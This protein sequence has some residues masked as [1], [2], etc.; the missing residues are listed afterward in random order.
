MGYSFDK[1][2][3]KN[4]LSISQVESLVSEL[5]GEP[6]EIEG[7]F[8]SKTICHCGEQHKLF[9]YD[10]TKLFRCYTEC[11]ETFDIISLVQ[12]VKSREIEN[13]SFANALKYVAAFFGIA[14]AINDDEDNFSFKLKDWDILNQFSNLKEEQIDKRKNIELKVYDKKI[15]KYLPTP[16]IQPWVEEGISVAAMRA[17]N[18]K[19]DP[20]NC[21]I[22]IP[23]YDINEQ[24]IGIRQRT[25]IKENEKYGKYMPAKLNGELYNHPLSFSLY[26]LNL[27]KNNIKKA[28]KAII[29]EAEKSTLLYY[30]YFGAENDISVACCGSNLIQ[31]QFN[32]LKDLGVEEII[33]AF[34]KQFQEIGDK[35]YHQWVNKLTEIHNKYGRNVLVS[36]VFDKK[37]DKLGYKDGPLDRGIDIFMEL[38]KERVYL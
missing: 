29:F 14:G 34:D 16:I 37:G 27:S 17:A 35:E 7:G 8:V 12:K 1:D 28:K 26:H 13:Y 32:L 36:F 5:G 9:Y 31:H 23:H 38:F 30:T 18:I 10:N 19:Y 15:L 24:L 33:I 20:V 3:V 21:S 2:E 25:L 6:R 11:N 22:I 4:S